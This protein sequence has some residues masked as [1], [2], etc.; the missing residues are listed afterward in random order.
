MEKLSSEYQVIIMSVCVLFSSAGVGRTGT[1]IALDYLLQQAEK[2]KEVDIVKL[3][4]QLRMERTT[5]IQTM[6]G[7]LEY[8]RH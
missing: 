1:F 2:E 5:M 4:N 6:V 8:I 7:C 3:V